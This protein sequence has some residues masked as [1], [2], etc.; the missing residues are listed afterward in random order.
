MAKFMVA[1]QWV[2]TSEVEVEADSLNHAIEKLY[3]S[4]GLPKGYY[5]DDSFNVNKE[6]TKHLN[7]NVKENE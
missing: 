2:M 3:D 1:C 6:D 4:N 5:L 7:R